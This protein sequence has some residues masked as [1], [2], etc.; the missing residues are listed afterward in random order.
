MSTVFLEKQGKIWVF[1]N[2]T[3]ENEKFILL[4]VNLKGF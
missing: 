4:N 2:H 3:V 1:T